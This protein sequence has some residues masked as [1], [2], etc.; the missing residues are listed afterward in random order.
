MFINT[1]FRK[2]KN[3]FSDCNDQMKL[4]SLEDQ[5]LAK[6][7]LILLTANIVCWGPVVCFCTY[8]VIS[9][10]PMNRSYIK[11]IAIFVIPFNSLINP[12]LYCITRNNFRIYINNFLLRYQLKRDIGNNV[13]LKS[14]YSLRSIFN[15]RSSEK[16]FH[17][18]SLITSV[19]RSSEVK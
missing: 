3:S 2:R 14:T 11:I 15:H 16:S 6:N 10:N 5:K 7:I 13:S 4:R 19:H 12:F 17:K 1:T 9:A 18:N 8:S